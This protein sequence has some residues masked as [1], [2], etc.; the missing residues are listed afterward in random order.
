MSRERRLWARLESALVGGLLGMVAGS[1]LSVLG[2]QLF[3]VTGMLLG[4]L[5]N[6]DR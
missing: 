4:F 6:P 1:F 3:A 5:A 2:A